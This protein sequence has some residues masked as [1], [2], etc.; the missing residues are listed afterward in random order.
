MLHSFCRWV[1][2]HAFKFKLSSQRTVGLVNCVPRFNGCGHYYA[3]FS[4]GKLHTAAPIY[5]QKEK[6]VYVQV[7]KWSILIAAERSESVAQTAHLGVVLRFYVAKS[8]KWT[9]FC[10]QKQPVSSKPALN[11]SGQATYLISFLTRVFFL[12]CHWNKDFCMNWWG[13]KAKTYPCC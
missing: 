11:V 6:R 13:I 3:H 1:K 7:V 10:F 5:C 2:T 12:S 9:V 8:Y 4:L